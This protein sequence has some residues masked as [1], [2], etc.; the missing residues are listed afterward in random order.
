M[1]EMATKRN[2][3]HVAA[4]KA[5]L[6]AVSLEDADFGGERFDKVFAFHV[7]A[8]WDQPVEALGAAKRALKRGGSLYLFNQPPG[9][10]AGEHTRQF[11]AQVTEVLER[12]GLS[13]ATALSDDPL[14]P[15]G[16]CL[17]A[18]AR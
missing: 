14:V 3:E 13:V 10:P 15:G 5:V 4:G 2:R 11:V 16:V 7:R 8:L 1:I 18:T 17:I 12:H 6:R 9:K